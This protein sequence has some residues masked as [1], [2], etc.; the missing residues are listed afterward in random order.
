MKRLTLVLS[1]ATL[2]GTAL[3]Q[4]SDAPKAT[5]WAPL[6]YQ[7]DQAPKAK[8]ATNPKLYDESAMPSS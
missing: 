4:P 1:L 6:T 8:P 2:A 3:A 7:P 5:T